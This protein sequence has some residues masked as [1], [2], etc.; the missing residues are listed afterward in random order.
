MMVREVTQVLKQ[1]TKCGEV[2]TGEQVNKVMQVSRLLDR[3]EVGDAEEGL[4]QVVSEHGLRQGP[5]VH[6]EHKIGH[7]GVV[8][9]Q[10]SVWRPPGI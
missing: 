9:N 1:V 2:M 4:V 6:L 8:M 3:W 7:E 5:E 10:S